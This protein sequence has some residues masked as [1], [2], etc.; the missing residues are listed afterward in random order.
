M[1]VQEGRILHFTS[2][3]DETRCGIT[4][5]SGYERLNELYSFDVTLVA[6]QDPVSPQEL[7]GEDV[8]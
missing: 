5:L 2:P 4:G 7:L 3:L 8:D 1:P 6:E